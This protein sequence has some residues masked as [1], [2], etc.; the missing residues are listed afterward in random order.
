MAWL[1]PAFSSF[2]CLQV[3]NHHFD[4]PHTLQ[5]KSIWNYPIEESAL[6]SLRK[7]SAERPPLKSQWEFLFSLHFISKI[8]V[9]ESCVSEQRVEA[10][11][12]CGPA[13]RSQAYWHQG[14]IFPGLALCW[15]FQDM[16]RVK[17]YCFS[18][19]GSS[20]LAGK[21]N[22]QRPH[23]MPGIIVECQEQ[24]RIQAQFFLS[25][26]GCRN[27]KSAK[28]QTEQSQIIRCP[29]NISNWLDMGYF[30]PFLYF[31]VLCKISKISMFR[32]FLPS[33]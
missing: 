1:W 4:E 27:W 25:G 5:E 22:I 10:E 33:L 20:N 8:V 21:T 28:M 6:R 9:L 7:G 3:E 31:S 11:L 13:G 15:A 26:P 16:Q 17:R 14:G 24:N 2:L 12:W 32:V 30:S 29:Q 18:A 19:P 23:V